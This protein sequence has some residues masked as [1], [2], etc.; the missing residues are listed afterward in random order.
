MT[1]LIAAMAISPSVPITALSLAYWKGT[2]SSAWF[3]I[4]FGFGYLFFL[5]LGIPIA[6]I[7][8]KKRRLLSCVIGGGVVTIAP[9]LLLRALSLSVSLHGFTLETLASYALLAAAG[10]LGGALF[11]LIAFANSKPRGA[12]A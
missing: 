11:W 5:L 8:L 6:A 4:F 10:G 12:N 3:A 1:R 9:L 2:G 7:F